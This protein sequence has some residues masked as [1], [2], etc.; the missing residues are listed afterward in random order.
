MKLCVHIMLIYV[1]FTI[2]IVSC[3]DSPNEPKG[4]DLGDLPETI[5]KIRLVPLNNGDLAK[6]VTDSDGTKWF[7]AGNVSHFLGKNTSSTLNFGEINSTTEL[8]FVLMN[9]GTQDV[10]KVQISTIDLNV[11]PASISRINVP[12]QGAE[13]SSLP[14][15]T[16]TKEHVIPHSGVGS[17]LSFNVGN[18]VDTL[19]LSYQYMIGIDT[20]D[21]LDDYDVVG[22]NM[23]A[24]IDIE[25]SGKPLVEYDYNEQ[26]YSHPGYSQEFLAIISLL[27]STID[28][29]HVKNN[30]N[31]PLQLQIIRDVDKETILD[32]SLYA[33]I[34]LDVS[35]LIRGVEY[36]Y[37]DDDLG[38]T[39]FMNAGN[40]ILFGAQT[41]QPFMFQVAG[42]TW[43]EGVC[44]ILI[45]EYGG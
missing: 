41:E 8:M 6:V 12:S 13:I 33:G 36:T 34:D 10:F 31:V 18:F 20:V 42:Y 27:T 35:G 38:N 32:T 3:V 7:P 14:I 28:T 22:S 25:L 19:S 43:I 23:G 45:D 11:S 21:V 5:G 17:L 29:I 39:T 26:Y 2:L 44:G 40:I 4:D 9:T 1:L 24:V 16:I 15:I 37:E 30:G